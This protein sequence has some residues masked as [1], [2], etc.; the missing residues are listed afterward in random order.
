VAD[1]RFASVWRREI[2][3]SHYVRTKLD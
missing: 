1:D 3:K 2:E